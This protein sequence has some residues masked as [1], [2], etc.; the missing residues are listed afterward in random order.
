MREFFFASKKCKMPKK[1]I[2][3]HVVC[4]LTF[5]AIFAL[6]N[7]TKCFFLNWP[8]SEKSDEKRGILNGRK[9]AMIGV[10]C[11][12]CRFWDYEI[13]DAILKGIFQL[14]FLTQ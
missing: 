8:I 14:N 12:C 13:A 11:S 9:T 2:K 10:V 4:M 6:V 5:V 1:T 7:T 3:S